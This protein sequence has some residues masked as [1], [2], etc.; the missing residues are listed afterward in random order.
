MTAL[1]QNEITKSSQFYENLYHEFFSDLKNA[2]HLMTQY[3]K[4]R[5][6][7]RIQSLV[8]SDYKKVWWLLQKDPNFSSEEL[9]QMSGNYQSILERSLE[10]TDLLIYVIS[11]FSVSMTESERIKLISDVETK[12]KENLKVLQHYNFHNGLISLQRAKSAVQ[13]EHLKSLYELKPLNQ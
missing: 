10:N 11:T 6:I 12:V 13:R 3:Y 1:K 5:E 2:K 9:K 7:A 8:V 4:I